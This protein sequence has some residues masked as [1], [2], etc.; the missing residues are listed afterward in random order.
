MRIK[1]LFTNNSMNFI[2]IEM[3]INGRLDKSITMNIK[4]AS[5]TSSMPWNS[6]S[7]IVSILL[8]L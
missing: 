2:K 3:N 5:A 4:N 8:N 7:S 1:M 6:S